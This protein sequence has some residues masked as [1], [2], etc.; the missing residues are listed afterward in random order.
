VY[1]SEVT[2]IVAAS[3][4]MGALGWSRSTFTVRPLDQPLVHPHSPWSL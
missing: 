3:L 4:L 2:V 1:S